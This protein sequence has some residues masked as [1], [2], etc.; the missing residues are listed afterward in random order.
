MF[1]QAASAAFVTTH[2]GFDQEWVGD[3]SPAG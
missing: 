3:G 1:R 2:L